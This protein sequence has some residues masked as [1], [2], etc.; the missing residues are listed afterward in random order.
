[1]CF[2]C[3]DAAPDVCFVLCLDMRHPIGLS[4]HLIFRCT[5]LVKWEDM[6][7]PDTWE[8]AGE[9]E[10]LAEFFCRIVH[11]RDERDPQ[12]DMRIRGREPLQVLEHLRRIRAK[13][14][15]SQRCRAELQIIK[16]CVHERQHLLE[17]FPRDEACGFDCHIDLA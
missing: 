5:E 10:Q 12:D 3:L 4:C 1:M 17:V 2:C 15:F 16:E 8:A 6:N 13:V 14:C 7:L 11:A 9:G